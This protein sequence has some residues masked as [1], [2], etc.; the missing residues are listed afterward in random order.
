MTTATQ[1]EII[2]PN[3]I[4]IGA[5]KAGTTSLCD[6]L[7]QH[8][9][10]FVC[11]PKEPKFF[12]LDENFQKGWEWYGKLFRD[13]KNATAIGEGSVNYTMRTAYPKTAQRIAQALPDAKLIYIVRHPLE[14]I[15]SN[16]R[17]YAISN[18]NPLEFNKAV[19]KEDF[20][21]FLV[22]RSKYWYQLQAYLDYFPP[23]QIKLLFFKDF[24]ANP[25][26]TLRQCFDYLGVDTDFKTANPE[27]PRNRTDDFRVE[28]SWRKK[29]SR[30]PLL[31]A[32]T[33]LVPQSFKKKLTSLP[34]SSQ[35]LILR[36]QWNKNVYQAVVDEIAED[37]ATFLKYSGKSPNYWSF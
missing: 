37:T 30:L 21:S 9:S 11:E 3:F 31:Q 10:V 18:A 5:A 23:E 36:P 24:I 16:W 6:L 15:V 1:T 20:R 34:L 17:M 22:D 26:D 13:A 19:R 32:T 7:N 8:P 2:K 12:S 27:K 33:K 28:A 14:R 4:V 29:L 25:Q 35:P